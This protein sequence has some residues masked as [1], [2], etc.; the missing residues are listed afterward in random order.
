MLTAGAAPAALFDRSATYRGRN[1]DHARA[2]IE[3]EVRV[4]WESGAVE[5]ANLGA[6]QELVFFVMSR[7]LRDRS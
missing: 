4:L 5:A 1:R 7:V 6:D 3:A 2:M